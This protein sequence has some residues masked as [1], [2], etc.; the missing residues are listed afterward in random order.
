MFKKLYDYFNVYTAEQM[1][2]EVPEILLA[3]TDVLMVQDEIICSPEDTDPRVLKGAFY[4][5]I[6]RDG[7]YGEPQLKTL[8]VYSENVSLEWQRMICSKEIVHV[9]DPKH[10]KAMSE[11][12]VDGLLHKLLDKD[13]TENYGL[14]DFQAAT[15]RLALYEALMILFPDGAREHAL[16]LLS[17]RKTTPAII[18]N[19]VG[20]PIELSNFVLSDN[21]VDVKRVLLA[22]H[23][24]SK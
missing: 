3:V 23:N 15:D 13:A 12:D 18:A 4:Q 17:E 1:P 11:N 10:S 22:I 9:C 21:W 24:G 14:A 19:W 8:I 16:K 7:V 20:L 2:V 6:E 5:S